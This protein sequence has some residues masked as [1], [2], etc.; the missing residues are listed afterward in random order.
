MLCFTDGGMKEKEILALEQ[1]HAN[2]KQFPLAFREFL[3]VAGKRDMS[4]TICHNFDYLQ[5]E[6]IVSLQETGNVIDRPFFVFWDQHQCCDFKFFY[7]DE[8]NEDPQV[9]YAMPGFTEEGY[10]LLEKQHCTFSQLV[11]T[12]LSNV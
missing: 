10:P 11:K 2:G 9:Y 6:A 5:Q 7:L 12:G 1:K 4:G 8:E 3:F